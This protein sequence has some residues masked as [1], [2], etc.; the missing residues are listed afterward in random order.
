M[1]GR[2]DKVKLS[3]IDVREL[4]AEWFAMLTDRDKQA[5]LPA[6]PKYGRY[7]YPEK[8][9]FEWA[10]N[11]KPRVPDPRKEADYEIARR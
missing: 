11:L 8:R 7:A 6:R 9:R 5:L 4:R 3:E 2:E 10:R 1:K